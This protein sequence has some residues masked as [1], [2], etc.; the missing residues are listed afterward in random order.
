MRDSSASRMRSWSVTSLIWIL[1]LL[2]SV[3]LIMSCS[4]SSTNPKKDDPE[5]PSYCELQ[6]LPVPTN[7]VIQVGSGSELN[8]AIG[9]ANSSGNVTIMLSDGVYELDEMLFIQAD[10]ITIRSASGNR[11]DAIIRGDGMTG[12]QMA[13]CMVEGT[14]FTIADVTLGWVNGAALRIRHDSDDALVHNVRFADAYEFMIRVDDQSAVSTRT[15]RGVVEWCL[16]EYTAGEAPST[17]TGGIFARQA[18]SWNVHHNIFRGIDGPGGDITGYAI[19][20]Y[21]SSSDALVEHNTIYNCDQ[22]IGLGL[23][24]GAGSYTEG[25]IR[26]NMV[27]ATN[28]AGIRLQSASY[29]SIY[30]NTIWVESYS[31]AI[32]YR[33]AGTQYASIINNLTNAPIISLDGATGVEETNVENA[34]LSWFVDAAAGD[35]R[36]AD[37]IGVVVDQGTALTA[38]EQDFDCEE[39]PKGEFYDLGADEW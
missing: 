17:Y 35:L 21:V 12:S 2:L 1:L 18:V 33:Y 8:D 39:R 11:D 9:V 5:E 20:F 10:S 4:D 7:T 29:V 14:D 22:G 27:H 25:I 31:A 23:G 28:E 16:F 3:V 32:E 30:N 26:N 13:L 37:S 6:P 15:D 24:N 34:E 19:L 38:V 36:L